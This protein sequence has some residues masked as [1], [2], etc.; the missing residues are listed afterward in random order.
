MMFV[1]KSPSRSAASRT[2]NLDM[3]K[4]TSVT[5]LQHSDVG[6]DLQQ[7]VSTCVNT[8]SCCR[9]IGWLDVCVDKQLN[10]NILI[11]DHWLGHLE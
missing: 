6:V 5:F 4:V 11:F 7:L 1:H 8:L 3:F 9:V 10:L 2:N